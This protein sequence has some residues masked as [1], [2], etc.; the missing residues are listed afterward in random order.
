MMNTWDVNKKGRPLDL[1]MLP[2]WQITV[3]LADGEKRYI[4]IPYSV[5]AFNYKTLLCMVNGMTSIITN[6]TL[7]L[8]RREKVAAWYMEI[9]NRY[10]LELEELKCTVGGGMAV[11]QVVMVPVSLSK[12]RKLSIEE[13]GPCDTQAVCIEKPEHLPPP[14]SNDRPAFPVLLV[15]ESVIEE[16]RESDDLQLTRVKRLRQR[17]PCKRITSFCAVGEPIDATMTST[18][19]NCLTVDSTTLT[20]STPIDISPPLVESTSVSGQGEAEGFE[21]VVNFKLDDLSLTSVKHSPGEDVPTGASLFCANVQTEKVASVAGAVLVGEPV[22]ATITSTSAA[23]LTVNCTAL[24]I[25]TPIDIIPSLVESTSVSS[26]VG[27]E[28]FEYVENFKITKVY[29]DLYKKIFSKYGH[30]ATKK[31]I[32]S[33]D[34]I[35][36]VCATSLMKIA[37]TMETVRGVDLSVVLLESWEGDIKDAETLQFNIKWLHKEVESREQV[38]EAS[39][40][41]Y[42]GL[43]SRKEEFET[44]LL[45]VKMNIK[46][47]EAKISSEHEAIREKIAEKNIFLFQPVLGNLFN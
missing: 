19:T 9:I 28:W 1:G 23:C 32:R 15:Q 3:T 18:S 39:Q 38:L 6:L 41:E 26:R 10:R 45:E 25:S 11:P 33:N 34:D 27:D 8:E 47:F 35:L 13:S 31:V 5:I 43:N 2:P 16:N 22:D 21:Y 12:K 14:T 29:A 7:K 37:S 30:I 24:T 4:K 17:C 20:I 42:V 36:L 44:E 40:L 46:K